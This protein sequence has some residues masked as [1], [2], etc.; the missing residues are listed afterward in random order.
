[1]CDLDFLTACGQSLQWH[2]AVLHAGC[3]V[4]V[5]RAIH[6]HTTA[7]VDA[8]SGRDNVPER[9]ESVARGWVT[10]A[11]VDVSA[12]AAADV[13]VATRSGVNGIFLRMAVRGGVLCGVVIHISM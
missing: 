9:T 6:T 2:Y 12:E 3:R 11:T 1:M 4:G 8:T 10:L 7:A 13:S 5:A